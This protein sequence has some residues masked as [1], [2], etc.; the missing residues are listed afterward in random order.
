MR[1]LLDWLARFVEPYVSYRFLLG[2]VLSAIFFS[3]L[4]GTILWLRDL[5]RAGPEATPREQRLRR[6]AQKGSLLILARSLS[7]ETFRRHRSLIV[8][9]TLLLVVAVALNVWIFRA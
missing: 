5:G 6:I 3:D 7:W 2:L 4:L 1:G 8:Q 9:I